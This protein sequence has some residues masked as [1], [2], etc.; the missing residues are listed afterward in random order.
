MPAVSIIS[1]KEAGTMNV[2]AAQGVQAYTS[3]VEERKPKQGLDQEDFMKL[4]VAQMQNQDPLNPM[5]DQEMVAQM[6][7]FSLLEQMEALNKSFVSAQALQ[8]IGKSVYAEVP[9]A[10]GGILPIAGQVDK[11]SLRDGKVILSVG[12][13]ELSMED[14]REVFRQNE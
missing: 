14:V 8:L 5:N 12:D 6:A 3:R 13:N 4:L 7:Q 1:F 2:H 10:D 11:V 9:Q